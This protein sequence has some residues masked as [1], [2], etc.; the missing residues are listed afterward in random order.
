MC[1]SVTKVCLTL[2]NPIDCSMP[3]FPVPYHLLEY[4]QIHVHRISNAD[5]ALYMLIFSMLIFSMYIL[6]MFINMFMCYILCLYVIICLYY[7]IYN[8]I[9]NKQ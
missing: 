4:A 1:C 2:C 5:S 8:S 3:G 7:A 9:T 6:D